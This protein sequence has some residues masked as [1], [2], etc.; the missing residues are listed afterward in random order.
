MVAF[1]GQRALSLAMSYAFTLSLREK[2]TETVM[3]PSC[4]SWV[5]SLGIWM[6]RRLQFQLTLRW[7]QLK[8]LLLVN[9]GEISLPLIHLLWIG[10]WETSIVSWNEATQCFP[11]VN[12]VGKGISHLVQGKVPLK[13][14]STCSTMCLKLFW[15]LFYPRVKL[16]PNKKHMKCD[17]YM[18][19]L[20]SDSP[21]ICWFKLNF[22]V[23]TAKLV[24]RLLKFL[25]I[26]QNEHIQWLPPFS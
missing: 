22:H 20:C 19:I 1:L 10:E 5:Q 13:L 8:V 15:K 25:V 24:N 4:L 17:F 6:R 11:T 7:R 21:L 2:G 12:I 14:N 3:M 26:Y 16:K 18:P 23:N 9:G